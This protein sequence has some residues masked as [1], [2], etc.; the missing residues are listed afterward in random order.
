MT[1][2]G[3]ALAMSKKTGKP[4]LADFTGSDWCGWCIRLKKEV[5]TKP[6]FAAWAKKN[7]ILLELDYPRRTP[8]SAAI[9]NQNE[10]LAAKYKIQGYP[11][12]LFLGSKGQVLWQ[13]GY[14]EG[15]PK[16]WTSKVDKM[17]KGKKV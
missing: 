7:V 3:A 16:V 10:G 5:F 14:D 17:L 9:K 11:T 2:Y 15:G 8:Q 6:D 4:I 12:I 13:Y 1:D